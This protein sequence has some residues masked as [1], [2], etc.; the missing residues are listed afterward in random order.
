MLSDYGDIPIEVAFS[1]V[2]ELV[3]VHENIHGAGIYYLGDTRPGPKWT[4]EN[5]N[6]FIRKVGL[7]CYIDE[8]KLSSKALK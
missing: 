1:N 5:F 4:E 6:T 2:V 7:R 8:H 3:I